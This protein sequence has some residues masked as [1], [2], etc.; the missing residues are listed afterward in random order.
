MVMI[1]SP[2][3][4]VALSSSTSHDDF[5]GLKE[6]VTEPNRAETGTANFCVQFWQLLLAG[7]WP[8]F[9]LM[10]EVAGWAV[11]NTSSILMHFGIW[12]SILKLRTVR[13]CAAKWHISSS[14]KDES[15]YPKKLKKNMTNSLGSATWNNTWIEFFKHPALPSQCGNLRWGFQEPGS[16]SPRNGGFFVGI[17]KRTARCSSQLSWHR[18]VPTEIS[19]LTMAV[20]Q[21]DVV[22]IVSCMDCW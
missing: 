2:V 10:P 21:C 14:A 4:P 16:S 5:L 7:Q 22:S 1:N 6:L 8:T 20:I 13:L 11:F 12:P 17:F 9:S 15:S 18:R 19:E 3:V